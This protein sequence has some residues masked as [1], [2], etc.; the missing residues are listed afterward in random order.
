MSDNAYN[1][2]IDY[3]VGSTGCVL[4]VVDW[5]NKIKKQDIN[6]NWQIAIIWIKGL[7]QQD[8]SSHLNP[9]IRRQYIKTISKSIIIGI[10]KKSGWV[11]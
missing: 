9:Y 7:W 6:V 4:N 10:M 8:D 5:L 11:Y 1:I 2:I 3:Y